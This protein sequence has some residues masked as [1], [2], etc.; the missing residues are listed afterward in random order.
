MRLKISYCDHTVQALIFSS[1]L[2]RVIMV[3]TVFLHMCVQ[4]LVLSITSGI[5][6]Y[7]YSGKFL[8]LSNSSSHS[9]C[10]PGG[11]MSLNNFQSTIDRPDSVSLKHRQ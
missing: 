7:L 2:I 9:F 11:A 5:T 1:I 4:N 8:Y 3:C 6:H 10:D